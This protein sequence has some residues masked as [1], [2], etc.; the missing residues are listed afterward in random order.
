MREIMCNC[1]LSS[2]FAF[3]SPFYLKSSGR[4]LLVFALALTVFTSLYQ[5]GFSFSHVRGGVCVC[6]MD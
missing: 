2:G 1:S 3:I 6:D 4:S 5:N